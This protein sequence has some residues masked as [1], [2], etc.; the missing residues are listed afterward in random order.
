LPNG[1]GFLGT[2]IHPGHVQQLFQR[3][4]DSSRQETQEG[5]KISNMFLFHA[6]IT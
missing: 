6:L 1:C 5:V 2:N 3:D 4:I